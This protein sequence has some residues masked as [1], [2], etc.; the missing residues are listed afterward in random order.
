MT[1]NERALTVIDNGHFKV[2]VVQI[3]SRLVRKIVL[4]LQEGHSVQKGQRIGMIRFG[5][6]VDLI[7]P[8]LPFLNIEVNPGEGV[9]AGLSILARFENQ[10]TR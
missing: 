4:Y 2:S 6:Q 9:K 3:A 1:Q 7:L 10:E 5:S 8:S